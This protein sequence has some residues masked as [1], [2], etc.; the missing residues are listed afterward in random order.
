MIDSAPFIPG[1]KALSSILTFNNPSWFI[2]NP[3]G[4]DTTVVST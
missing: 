3:T 1:T 4:Y 2:T